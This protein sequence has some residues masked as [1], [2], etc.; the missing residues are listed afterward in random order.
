MQLVTPQLQQPQ[1]VTSLQQPGPV[2]AMQINGQVVAPMTQGQAQAVMAAQQQAPAMPAGAAVGV[3]PSPTGAVA[4]AAATGAHVFMAAS[5]VMPQ[6]VLMMQMMQPQMYITTPSLQ[7]QP[8]QPIQ[9]QQMQQQLMLVQ[10]PHAQ[11][12][13]SPLMLQLPQTAGQPQ[14]T[15]QTPLNAITVA[16]HAAELLIQQLTA[17][18]QS[19]GTKPEFKDGGVDRKKDEAGLP[20][21]FTPVPPL[22]PPAAIDELATISDSGHPMLP[23]A[24]AATSA[25]DT[26]PGL[27]E[28]NAANDDVPQMLDGD[29]VPQVKEGALRVARSTRHESLAGAIAKRLRAARCVEVQAM[30]ATAVCLALRALT[31]CQIHLGRENMHVLVQTEFMRVPSCD[32][33]GAPHDHPGLRFLARGWY[34]QVPVSESMPK[35]IDPSLCTVIPDKARPAPH[36]VGGVAGAIARVVRGQARQQGTPI[37]MYSGTTP[38]EFN[39]MMKSISLAR[40]MI[41]QDGLDI[42]FR[43]TRLHSKSPRNSP[44][45]TSAECVP[46][47]QIQIFLVNA[48]QRAELAAKTAQHDGAGIAL[49]LTTQLRLPDYPRIINDLAC[50]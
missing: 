46:E 13:Q 12:T 10:H 28:S 14:V 45:D 2:Y 23:A 1:L 31:L 37:V 39:L 40:T 15:P 49:D 44:R 20:S 32:S 34:S 36:T 48:P 29:D 21:P 41:A 8:V 16:P 3:Q 22:H 35:I 24:A 17:L 11:Q 25:D 38:A 5:Q 30:G 4:P 26:M 42:H 27:T 6:A 18:Q 50:T 19:K 47:M 7:A 33:S 43:S 9:Q